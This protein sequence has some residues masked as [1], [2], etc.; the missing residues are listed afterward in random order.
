MSDKTK[1]DIIFK[2]FWRENERFAD[3]FNTVV[4]K[5]KEVI[6]PEMLQEMDTDVSGVIEFKQYKETIARTRD[7][8]K[9]SAYGIE[10]VVLGI[11][12]Q[13]S[14][15]YAMPLRTMIYD[16][17]GYLKEYQDITRKRKKEKKE[18]QEEFLSNMRKEDRLHPIITIVI[19]YGE[20]LWD[21]PFS[22]GDMMIE[23]PQEI[24]DI[25]IDYRMN[26]LQVRDSSQ[27]IFQNEDVQT[28]FEISREIFEEQFDKIKEQ[29]RNRDI[30][31]E[32]LTVIG[33]ITDSKAIIKQGLES[34]EGVNMCKALENLENQGKQKGIEEGKLEAAKIMI[35]NGMDLEF[36]AE[37]LNLK[38][39]LVE[40]FIKNT[41]K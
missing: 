31:S 30:K 15:H 18:T 24:K 27:Y 2:D 32:L 21:G 19:Y 28:V 36:V 33:K 5:G 40:N 35:E 20:T 1:A 11:E 17:L 12:S 34:K 16:A 7:V 41:K 22:L 3:L 13:K 29:Y 23:M 10:F 8:V 25:F 39:E 26:L 38:K 9:K 4:F 6:R 37:K 14:I